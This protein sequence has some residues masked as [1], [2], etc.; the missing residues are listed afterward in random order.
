MTPCLLLVSPGVYRTIR[1]CIGH[2]IRDQPYQIYQQS[3][4][5]LVPLLTKYS[6]LWT[7]KHVKFIRPPIIVSHNLVMRN[8]VFASDIV[9]HFSMGR[10]KLCVYLMMLLYHWAAIIGGKQ[11]CSPFTMLLNLFRHRHL[12]SYYATSLECASVIHIPS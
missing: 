12:F 9:G 3:V 2:L 10:G 5:V 4:P 8:E 7:I 6:R 11:P 1:T